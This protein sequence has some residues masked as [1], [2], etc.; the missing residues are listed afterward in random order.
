MKPACCLLGAGT[1]GLQTRV[2]Q[3]SREQRQS[4]A[5]W[6]GGGQRR[7]VAVWAFGCRV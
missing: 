5:V 4:R 7:G 3:Q 1:R 6:G 2:V